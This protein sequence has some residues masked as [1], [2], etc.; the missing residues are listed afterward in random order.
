MGEIEIKRQHGRFKFNH[1]NNYIKYK[2]NEHYWKPEIIRLA[3]KEKEKEKEEKR[4]GKKRKKGKQKT[5]PNYMQLIE[6]YFKY[7]EI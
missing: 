7:K 4:K 6:T 1:I 5:K 2:Q 3:G